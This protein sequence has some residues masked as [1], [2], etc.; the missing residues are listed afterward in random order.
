MTT[1]P[2]KSLALDDTPSDDSSVPSDPATRRRLQNRLNQ[3][4][5][6][7]RKAL[8]SKTHHN[9]Q[10]QKWVV[11]VKES[12]I[13]RKTRAI[14]ETSSHQNE[15]NPW[16][17]NQIQR[18]HFMTKFHACGLHMIKNPALSPNLTLCD[19]RY[20]MLC[21]IFTNANFMGLT[22]DLLNED[23]ASQFNLVGPST[24]HLPASLC[25]SQKQKNIIHH[26]WIDLI[27]MLSLRESVLDRVEVLDEEELCDD[28]YG[29]C[30]SSGQ[31]GLR[32]W[33]ESWD[34]SAYEASE[35]VIQKWSWMV[36]ECPD[37]I[38][39]SN[40]WRKQRG[41]KAIVFKS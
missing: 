30:A 28:L 38:K 13:L 1:S 15:E 4:A 40:Y 37:L 26:P 3:R 22:F 12:D 23:I 11:Y 19:T 2:D 14:E 9:P 27:P 33:G 24:L 29:V 35:T 31:S 10:D 17:L 21:A 36:Q 5:S 8:F 32:I 41:E 34:P 16:H 20:N 6:R 7:K 25:P 18:N 39:S